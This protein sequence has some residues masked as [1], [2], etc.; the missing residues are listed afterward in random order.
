M[1]VFKI[2]EFLSR[3]DAFTLQSVDLF[4]SETPERLYYVKQ[5]CK[6]LVLLSYCRE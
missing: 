6:V 4:H 5:R 1:V 2:V 3:V